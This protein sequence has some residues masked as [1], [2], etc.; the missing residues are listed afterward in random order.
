M[1]NANT[2]PITDEPPAEESTGIATQQAL[3]SIRA[4]SPPNYDDI[5]EFLCR[6][7]WVTG[8]SDLHYGQ[9]DP[10]MG[11]VPVD[12][13]TYLIWL[14]DSPQMNHLD[15]EELE[16]ELIGWLPTADLTVLGRGDTGNEG[17]FCII[18]ECPHG[19]GY[20]YEQCARDKY[21]DAVNAWLDSHF[22]PNPDDESDDDEQDDDE[23]QPAEPNQEAG[24]KT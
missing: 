20:Q 24:G 23:P 21:T 15:T 18:V 6:M 10:V 12:H 11:V 22:T 16:A 13:D 4:S 14:H 7:L 9:L 1:T 19:T 8:Y 3:A 2:T 5:A 17:S